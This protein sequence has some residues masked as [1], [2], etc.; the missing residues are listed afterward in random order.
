M[1]LTF[2]NLHKNLILV[3]ILLIGTVAISAQTISVCNR[4]GVDLRLARF[5]LSPSSFFGLD[6]SPMGTSGCQAK[7]FNWQSIGNG[8]CEEYIPG[9][10][11]AYWFAVQLKDKSGSW[12]STSYS[13][14]QKIIDGNDRGWSGISDSSMCVKNETYSS[15][16]DRIVQGGWGAVNKEVCQAGYSKVKVNL[17]AQTDERTNY[18]V[19]VPFEEP[20]A[21][22]YPNVIRSSDG[23]VAPACGYRWMTSTDGDFRV[24]LKPG[25]SA[26][27][28]GVAPSKGYRWVVQGP[29]PNCSVELIRPAK[30]VPKKPVKRN[31]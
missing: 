1:R 28:N 4:S 27:A 24:N 10:F 16:F 9:S 13:V 12:Y 21:K 22:S 8:Y 19:S 3:F 15:Y 18:T 20:P 14:N 30:S 26:S 23:K 6:C 5:S 7:M 29:S 2:N 31:R 25:F 17:L 11:G